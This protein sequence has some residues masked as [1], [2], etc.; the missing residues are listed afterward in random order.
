MDIDAC[1]K[2]VRTFAEP[3]AILRKEHTI[4]ASLERYG[5]KS[6]QDVELW[7]VDSGHF[8][9]S[10]VAA[11]KSRSAKNAMDAM[12]RHVHE[13]I[14]LKEGMRGKAL[15]GR[16]RGLVGMIAGL[17]SHN[18]QLEANVAEVTE[19]ISDLLDTKGVD[20]TPTMDSISALSEVCDLIAESALKPFGKV[21][22]TLNGS[23]ES[24]AVAVDAYPQAYLRLRKTLATSLASSEDATP[25]Q[26]S[27]ATTADKDAPISTAAVEEQFAEMLIKE[28]MRQ[29][30]MMT[31]AEIAQY[32]DPQFFANVIAGHQKS[33]G[34]T[35]GFFTASGVRT[36]RSM[37]K[38][39]GGAGLVSGLPE[40]E[41]GD[42]EDEAVE[43]EDE[44]ETE[45]DEFWNP[46]SSI[47]PE[48]RVAPVSTKSDWTEYG[49][50]LDSFQ[51]RLGAKTGRRTQGA[52]LMASIKHWLTGFE[53][54][55][56]TSFLVAVAGILMGLLATYLMIAAAVKSPHLLP[57]AQKIDVILTRVNPGMDEI[58]TLAERNLAT[59][60]RAIKTAHVASE[61][62]EAIKI[63][64]RG[65]RDDTLSL[66]DE[67]F[68][69]HYSSAN[70]HSPEEANF[71]IKFKE[72]ADVFDKER[73]AVH[74]F[75][76][77]LDTPDKIQRQ[78]NYER[79][80]AMEMEERA[81]HY[82]KLD[83][84][85][86]YIRAAAAMYFLKLA[87]IF[88]N[89]KTEGSEV[90]SE[91]VEARLNAAKKKVQETLDVMMEDLSVLQSDMSILG[92]KIRETQADI[93][94]MG[95][96]FDKILAVVNEAPIATTLEE[97]FVGDFDIPFLDLLWKFYA[98]QT[99]NAV[100]SLEKVVHFKVTNDGKVLGYDM[101]KFASIIAMTT[102]TTKL[103]LLLEALTRVLWWLAPVY[104][105]GKLAFSAV[106]RTDE[107][108]SWVIEKIAHSLSP[109]T[110]DPPTTRRGQAA[111]A[112]RSLNNI[113]HFFTNIFYMTERAFDAGSAIF[114]SSFE[115]SMMVN[116]V[117]LYGV[118]TA[119]FGA[120]LTADLIPSLLRLTASTLAFS[121]TNI[122]TP[123]TFALG[124]IVIRDGS[125]FKIFPS[126]K[127][128]R[129]YV[130]VKRT[131]QTVGVGVTV[132]M[133]YRKLSRVFNPGEM[134]EGELD[135]SAPLMWHIEKLKNVFSQKNETLQ[136]LV[137]QAIN[138]TADTETRSEWAKYC[139]SEPLKLLGGSSTK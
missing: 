111:D 53:D 49:R 44:E 123:L 12:Q 106:R 67:E 32:S 28:A 87:K 19:M 93:E 77:T 101:P 91:A 59:L 135:E 113:L 43:L 35:E 57:A 27:F 98:D 133:V 75:R 76:M 120:F 2:H 33:V 64:Y 34:F 39:D 47:P 78:K 48:E 136:D 25:K 130:I 95:V 121:S 88:A 94:K 14:S 21:D 9:T 85:D 62:L 74:E 16:E 51:H 139:T 65:G 99:V 89:S 55:S 13:K 127:T 128:G 52:T 125:K 84:P 22:L 58:Y 7:A 132:Y 83:D 92:V 20:S 86:E 97:R 107:M 26:V 46:P 24:L 90:L 17:K 56:N 66:W 42:D 100:R 4:R 119:A 116:S 31:D 131:A 54:S 105:L 61:S 60:D 124:K 1:F 37:S 69:S 41:G 71:M 134:P 115:L 102:T 63:D 11:A 73:T 117:L 50:V 36:T 70:P 18:A 8:E 29:T 103:T 137:R 45:E 114:A 108:S 72:L 23:K 79:E 40:T 10:G 110:G 122:T 30:N 3:H 15:S 6:V 96:E 109:Y 68:I 82:A 126:A 129:F 38:K 104:G 112:L 138:L 80:W 81:S 118:G 5:A